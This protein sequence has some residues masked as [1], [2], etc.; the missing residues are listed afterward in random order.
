MKTEGKQRPADAKSRGVQLFC[1]V[2]YH[3][4][5]D[6]TRAAEAPKVSLTAAVQSAREP[7]TCEVVTV[8]PTRT[9][10]HASVHTF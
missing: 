1:E 8:T 4:P 7:W 9:K 2:N 6:G 3:G 10:V 5:E